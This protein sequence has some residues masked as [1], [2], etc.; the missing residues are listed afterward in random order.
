ML[1]LLTA[2][3]FQTN[4][5]SSILLSMA[6]LAITT[7]GGYAIHI[8]N[9]PSYLWWSEVLSPQRWLLPVIVAEEFSHDTLANTAGQ[10]LCRNKQ[11]HFSHQLVLRTELITLMSFLTGPASRDYR[12]ASLPRPERHSN[13]C[14]SL[15]AARK[16]HTRFSGP[17]IVHDHCLAAHVGRVVCPHVLRFHF[18]HSEIVQQTKPA[19]ECPMRRRKNVSTESASIARL[20]FIKKFLFSFHF[21]L[22]N[23]F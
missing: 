21:F 23:F 14:R 5:A 1:T 15:A 6:M 16:P 12:A 9:I 2:H 17:G 19:S 11:V 13:T 18:E 7:V 10:Q 8:A 20:E 4:M 3:L 22:I